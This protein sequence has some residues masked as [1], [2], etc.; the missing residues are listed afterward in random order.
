MGAGVLLGARVEKLDEENPME[1]LMEGKIVLHIYMT[2]TTPAQE[3]DFT[4]EYD[5]EYVNSILG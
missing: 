1:Q 5:P 2:P 4:L 3:I